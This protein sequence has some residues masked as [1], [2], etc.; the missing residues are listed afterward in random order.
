MSESGGIRNIERIEEQED[1]HRVPRG[2]TL[3]F[4]VAGAACVLFAVLALSGRTTQLPVKK[5]DPLGELLAQRARSAAAPSSALAPQ[6]LSPKDVTFPQLLSDSDRLP[7]ALAAIRS[8]ASA[9]S[10]SA[11]PSP[12]PTMAQPPP[13]TDRLPVVPLP[14][15]A[16]LEASPIVTRPRDALTRA[17][18]EAAR[19][20]SPSA[21]REAVS[22]GHEGGYQLQVSSFHTQSEAQAFAD[23]LR[24]RGHKAYV[25]EANVPGRGTWYRV[26][27]GPFPT[28]HA[29]AEYRADFEEKEH[30]VPF[31][32]T[33]ETTAKAH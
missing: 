1:E 31:V 33:P 16:I 18:T 20:D 28:Q 3:A 21:P 32:V 24:A 17:A 29:A 12:P 23:Q 15:Q 22:P 13:A 9:P 4:V 5:S 10:T 26:R 2:V 30:V 25:L 6:E 19:I 27:I 14:A 7:T 11:P 8:T